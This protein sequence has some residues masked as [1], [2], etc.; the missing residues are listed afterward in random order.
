MSRFSWARLWAMMVKEFIQMKRDRATFAMIIGIPIMELIIFGYAINTNPTHLSTVV[1]TSDYSAF[2]RNFL[3]GMKSSSYFDIIDTV[4]DEN[5]ADYYLKT[6]KAQFVIN[7][8]PDF[9]RSL[10]RGEH[11]SL[12]L[13]ADA[14]DPV[15]IGNAV[16]A[17][18][19]LAQ[20]TLD[21]QLSGPLSQ[22]I[23]KQNVIDVRVHSAYNP[24]ANTQHNIVPG[25]IG[26]ILTMTLVMITAIAI[27]RERERGTMENLL[28]TPIQPLEIIIG[29]ILPF[30]IVGYIQLSLILVLSHLLFAVPI[31]GN[32]LLLL[33]ATLPF[34]V[35]NLSVGLTLSA[36]AKN[37]LQ[38]G[39]MGMFF[40]L[41]SILLSGFAFPFYGMP[42]WAQWIGECLPMT[43][44][45]RID[46]G[47]L[48]KGNGLMEIWPDLWPI[49]LFMTIAISI[50]V[51]RFRRTLD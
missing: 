47:I 29:K 23:P 32:V 30:I 41:P 36:I 2:T 48:L 27:T 4:N 22:Q 34:I 6:G 49:L 45:L 9:S 46:R 21:R 26:I 39:Q 3:N 40:F 18:R 19:V 8:P 14:T 20:T 50:A 33:V 10:I 7:I 15:T 17:I 43:H 24:T 38:A 37:Q 51:K 11:P 44:Y 25:L 1:I 16:N 42:A 28:A 31:Q 12:L 13:Q 5:L 35:A